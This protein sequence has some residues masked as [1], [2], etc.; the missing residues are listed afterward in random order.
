MSQGFFV[1]FQKISK[2]ILLTL[3]EVYGVV[4]YLV[5]GNVP[6]KR[7]RKAWWQIPGK[8]ITLPWHNGFIYFWNFYSLCISQDF[9]ITSISSWFDIAEK[10]WASI[11][12]SLFTAVTCELTRAHMGLTRGS[13][14]AHTGYMRGTHRA[15]TGLTRD[16]HGWDH[17][18]QSQSKF[19][20]VLFYKEVLGETM[21]ELWQCFYS[22]NDVFTL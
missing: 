5:D 15:Y 12:K 3:A 17:I 1:Q 2:K 14:K 6:Y 11:Q 16:S 13:H 7:V 8:I 20:L 4:L 10:A 9:S 21:I 18:S 22:N 19:I